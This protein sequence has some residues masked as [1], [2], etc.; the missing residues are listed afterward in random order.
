MLSA[1]HSGEKVLSEEYMPDGTRVRVLLDIIAYGRL[2]RYDT[3]S[4]AQGEPSGT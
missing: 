3:S 2:K 1:L 4:A